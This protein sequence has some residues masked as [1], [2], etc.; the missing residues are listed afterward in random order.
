MQYLEGLNNNQKEAVLYTEGPLLIIAGAGAGKTKTLTTRIIHL[1]HEHTS[2]KRILAVTFTNKAANEMRE[3][4]KNGIKALGKPEVPWIATF[5]SLGVL[6]LREMGS[7]HGRGTRFKI[8]DE[9]DSIKVIKEVL[10]QMG[11]D[12]KENDPKSIKNKISTL[13]NKGITLTIFREQLET[14]YDE[15]LVSIWEKYEATLE[16]EKG[17]DFDDLILMPIALLKRYSET[18]FRYQEQFTYILVDEYQDTNEV[19]YELIRLLLSEKHNICAVGDA[20]QNIYS[21]RGATL[22]NIL[23]FEHDFP[24]A[25]IVFLE[26]NYRSTKTI[27]DA[28]NTVIAKNEMRIPKNLFTNIGVGEKIIKIESYDEKEEAKNIIDEYI[29]LWDTGMKPDDCAILYR[30]NF[31]SRV[32]E[33]EC[34]R[35]N[36]PYQL[37]GTKFFQRKEVKDVIAYIHAALFDERLSDIKRIINMPTRGIGKTTVLKIFAGERDSLPD[38]TKLAVDNFFTLLKKIKE[39][40]ENALPSEL[41]RFIIEES[42]LGE[43]YKNE[44]EFERLENIEELVSLATDYDVFGKEKG[45]EQLLEHSALESDQDELEK[46]KEGVRLM[47]IHA[48]KGLEFDTV[49]IVGLEHGLFPHIFDG[50]D[51]K[52][53]QEEERRLMYVAITRARKRLYLSHATVR[54]IFGKRELTIPSEFLYDIPNELLEH[55]IPEH[56]IKTIYLE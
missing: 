13:K 23:R 16:K 26:E 34:L 14:S 22:K 35:R 28:A 52:E 3:R 40:A 56:G 17:F 6:L 42:K 55:R 31:Q 1:I 44:G 20:D 39:F 15:F 48:A 11:L 5:H 30:A 33:E 18:R 38:K 4:V 41:I 9:D 43:Y 54:T 2:P 47:T 12:T 50:K 51:K 32:F 8:F 19:Q 37:V 24:G 25:K 46:P 45:L 53:D 7:L 49:F 21:W 10:Q 29:A 27:L 36:I